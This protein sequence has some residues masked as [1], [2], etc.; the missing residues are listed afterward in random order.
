MDDPYER[1]RQYL[2]LLARIQVDPWLRAK[3]D[4]SGV[5]QQTLLEAHQCGAAVEGRPP[6][7]RLAWLRQI[8][9]HNLGDELR[10]FR[11]EKRD[12]RREIP[13]DT[14]L[15]ESAAKLDAWLAAEGTSPSAH[16]VREE[17]VLRLVSALAKLPDAQREA[18]ILQ[19]WQGWSVAEI[20]KHLERTPA[21]VGGLLK[22]A[23]ARMREMLADSSC[24]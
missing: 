16:A 12:A 22:R 5:V 23:L 21:A 8:L 20:A 13:L 14:A 2:A 1:Y 11:G 4:L 17:D 15:T 24:G 19:Y 18:L 9:A 10:K 7:E 6:A 3:I